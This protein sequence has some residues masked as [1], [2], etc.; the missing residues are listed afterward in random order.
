MG[1]IANAFAPTA[2]T[3]RSLLV[4]IPEGFSFEQAAAIPTVFSHRLLR[5]ASTSPDLKAGEK[6]LIH[7]GAGGVG[8][9]A[10]EIARHLGAEVYA[11]ASPAKWETL[12]ELG[13]DARP[14]RLLPGPRVQGALRGRRHRRRAQLPR[15]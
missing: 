10:I 4:P 11:T 2:T 13:L 5:P 8:M 3:E 6:V 15:R 14:H 7:A 12:E 1:L 9:A